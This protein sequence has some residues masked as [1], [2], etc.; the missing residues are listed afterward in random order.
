MR[1]LQLCHKPPFPPKDGGC[2][3]IKNIT[4][5]LIDAGIDLTVI[6]IETK[7]HPF[8]KESVP[9]EYKD[10]LRIIPI[11]VDTKINMVDAF[12]SLVTSDSYNI[13]RFFTPDVD[14]VLTELLRKE[15][16]DIIHLESLFVSPYIGTIQRLSKGKIVLRS[17]NLEFMIW[18]RLANE[19]NNIAKKTYL[20]I[21]AKQLRRFE[22][23]TIGDVH[24]IASISFEDEAKYKAICDS[25]PLKNIP[26]G[27]DIEDYTPSD[28]F[29]EKT[30]FHLGSLEWKPNLEGILWFINEIWP[31]FHKK[32]P[33]TKFLLA[34]RDIPKQISNRKISG[35][36]VVGEVP[37]AQE[38]IKASGVMIVPL[39][40]G[41]GIRVKIIEGMALGVPIVSTSIGMEGIEHDGSQLLEANTPEE[42]MT[43]ME[44]CLDVKVAQ[45]YGENARQLAEHKYNNEALIVELISFYKSLM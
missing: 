17:H 45:T 43:K 23:H 7:K 5:G 12:S 25:T 1:I 34:G 4:C 27:I 31:A 44:D 6:T 29:K 35:V 18:E 16:F 19:Q 32:H 26:F 11:F 39:H 24:G 28:N 30:F 38:F 10:K 42:F 33:E 3:A 9:A 20:N 13:S 21:L 36:E 2:I 37:D 14:I 41:G 8:K 40:A 22:I 15:K